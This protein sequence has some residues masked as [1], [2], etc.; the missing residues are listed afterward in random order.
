MGWGAGEGFGVAEAG[1]EVVEV[2]VDVFVP[3]GRGGRDVG[4]GVEGVE[5]GGRGFEVLAPGSGCGGCD[6]GEE[7]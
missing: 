1:G 7:G 3:V 2:V 6:G 5:E 4:D